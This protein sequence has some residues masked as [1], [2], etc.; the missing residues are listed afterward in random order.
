MRRN[1]V[2]FAFC[3]LGCQLVQGQYRIKSPEEKAGFDAIPQE[4]AFLHFNDNMLLAGEYLYYKFYCLNAKDHKPSKVSRIAYVELVGEDKIPVFKHKI[5]LNS[6]TGTGDFFFPTSISTGTYKL[7][8]YTQWMRNSS[9]ELFFTSDIYI[10]NPYLELP[11]DTSTVND[12]ISGTSIDTVPDIVPDIIGLVDS[13]QN[14]FQIG[15]TLPQMKYSS[16]AAVNLRIDNPKGII[17]NYSISVRKKDSFKLAKNIS[18]ANYI[19]DFQVPFEPEG[20]YQNDLI[21]LPEIRGELISGRVTNDSLGQ[22]Y[23]SKD[24]SLSIPESD[25]GILRIVRTDSEGSFYAV[26]EQF[27]NNSRAEV[28]L[29]EED[30][31]AYVI[32]NTTNKPIDYDKLKFEPF[33]LNSEMNSAILERS[34]YNQIES[35]YFEKKQDSIRVAPNELDVHEYLTNIFNLDDY[36]RFPSLRETIVEIIDDV[37]IRKLNGKFVFQVRESD[38]FFVDSSHLPLLMVDGVFIK[39]HEALLNY[40]T[41]NIESISFSKDRYYVGPKIFHGIISVKTS[42]GDYQSLLNSN[43]LSS[44]DIPGP[45]P[46]KKYYQQQY[47]EGNSDEHKNLPDFRHQLMW[48]PQLELSSKSNNL[49]FFTSDNTGEFEIC[50]EGFTNEGVPVSLSQTFYVE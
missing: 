14:D 17:G 37:F 47:G 30:Q 15:I 19:K 12:G 20:Y 11:S 40:G 8:G 39:D 43:N 22:P 28:Q 32:E 3:L 38:R 41:A 23:A 10:L 7:I 35:A 2:L 21:Y 42:N 6:G 13:I 44:W 34:I 49:I 36:T 18:A 31:N 24:V 45:T 33:P 9:V 25:R 46:V 50:L 1:I 4:I 16:R 5:A 48:K 29:L 26:I 27:R